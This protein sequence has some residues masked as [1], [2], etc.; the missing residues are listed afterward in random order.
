MAAKS[1]VKMAKMAW[2][3]GWQ[4]E[5]KRLSEVMAKI[6]SNE[7]YNK[8]RVNGGSGGKAINLRQ[9][10]KKRVSVAKQWQPLSGAAG[11]RAGAIALLARIAR[12][13]SRI[14]LRA[15]KM[16]NISCARARGSSISN[17]AASRSVPKAVNRGNNGVALSVGDK[18]A[19]AYIDARQIWRRQQRHHSISVCVSSIATA[20]RQRR[21]AWRRIAARR[22]RP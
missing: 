1:V 10:R 12:N 14:A 20:Y 6:V 9:R 13:G 7:Q 11:A 18:S 16:R 8:R 5:M 19:L 4:N 15:L 22:H 17:K 21:G 2:R 3:G